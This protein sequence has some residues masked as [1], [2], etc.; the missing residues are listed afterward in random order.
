MLW[1][2]QNFDQLFGELPWSRKARAME[3]QWGRGAERGRG[4]MG[5]GW[6]WGRVGGTSTHAHTHT[7]AHTHKLAAV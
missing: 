6:G 1:G 5:E 7:I 3:R 4:G 2:A